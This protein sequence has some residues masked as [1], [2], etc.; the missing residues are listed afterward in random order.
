MDCALVDLAAY[1]FATLEDAERDQLDE[2][3]V[4]CTTC[5]RGYLALKR[6]IERGSGAEVPSDQARLRLRRAVEARFRPARAARASWF[7]RP[8]PLYQGLAVAAI[9]VLIASLVPTLAR[10]APPRVA[11]GPYVDT[12]RPSA[13]SL[14]I[15]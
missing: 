3:L 1:H 14:T 11:A 8:I 9:A 2:H 6:R 12:S 4:A 15:Y 10:Q 7:R 13:E 5:L